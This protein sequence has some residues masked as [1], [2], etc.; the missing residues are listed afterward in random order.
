M[1]DH[2]PPY[3]HVLLGLN[4]DHCATVREARYRDVNRVQGEMVEPDPVAFALHAQLA[5]ADGITVHP[6]EDERHIRRSDVTRLREVLQI[7]LNLEM[8]CTDEMVVFAL[9]VRPA[10]VCVVPEKREEVT[11]EGGLDVT[12]LQSKLKALVQA[13]RGAGIV[14]SLFIDPERAQIEA[15]AVVEAPMVELHTGSF[16]NAWYDAG[17]RDVELK[18]LIEGA[19]LAH[20]LGLKVNIGHGINY[21]NIRDARNIPHVREMNIGH[22]IVSRSL[23]TGVH[24]AVREMKSLMNPGLF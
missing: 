9:E 19:E 16:A 3:S 14:T 15:A 2:C 13:M 12:T 4:I 6:R 8:A 18:K 24:E 23:F 5:G 17:T 22:A 21:A 10:A 7:P 1:P 20:A 11:T